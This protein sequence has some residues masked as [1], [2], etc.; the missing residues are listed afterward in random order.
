MKNTAKTTA[1]IKNDI[2]AYLAY[3]KTQKGLAENSLTAYR[4]D[5]EDFSAYL[6]LEKIPLEG[7]RRRHFRGF[8]AELHRKKLSRTSVNRKIAA[9]KGF[10]RYRLRLGRADTA[11]ILEV[12]S[13]RKDNYLPAF[14]FENEARDL[15]HFEDPSKEGSRDRALFHLLFATGI[16]ISELTALQIDDI[17]FGL[18][19]IKVLGKGNK[20]RI[21]LFG[22]KCRKTL[23][24]YLSVRELFGT[25]KKNE[26][27]SSTLFLNARGKNLTDRGVRY[28][29][30]KR[31]NQISLQK[32]I[33]PHSLR[34]SFATTLLANGADIRTVQILLGHAQLSTTQIYTHL[35]LDELK[36]IHYN[37]HPHGK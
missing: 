19:Q 16:R 25:K 34:H 28:I 6:V 21:V 5:L 4:R 2:E 10:F 37:Y 12:E 35:G 26:P 31:V 15:I 3:L 30:D 20:E 13:P 9:I 36:D 17:D 18:K 14:L 24:T 8:L 22:P 23:E 29:L 33:S 32:K 1:M 11:A 27:K 7:L